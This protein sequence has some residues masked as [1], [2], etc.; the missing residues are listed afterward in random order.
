MSIEY[1]AGLIDGEGSFSIQIE[2]RYYTKTPNLR[3]NPRLVMS[4]KYG[5]F[6][7]DE[8]IEKFG[9]QLY[10]YKDGM[11]RWNLS[12]KDLLIKTT[13][14]LIPHLRI[15]KQ[16]A[17][18]FLHALSLMPTTRKGINLYGGE[19]AITKQIAI[20]IAEIALTLNPPS[21]RK[22]KHNIS[23]LEKIK[24]IYN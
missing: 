9:G 5:T 23:Y 22:S 2:I 10:T 4:L 13:E 17:K 6:V 24:K 18:N 8:L 7:L 20:K 14:M 16:I 1:L 15:K 21:S 19:R 12:K 11:K 3:I